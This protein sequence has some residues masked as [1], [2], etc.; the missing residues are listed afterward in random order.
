[1]DS[2]DKSMELGDAMPLV[3]GHLGIKHDENEKFSPVFVE[4]MI[5]H[6]LIFQPKI[7]LEGN[8]NLKIFLKLYY[9]RL[10]KNMGY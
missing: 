8:F 1:M 6:F 3:Y 4:W 9:K 5:I 2:K 7:C 10:K